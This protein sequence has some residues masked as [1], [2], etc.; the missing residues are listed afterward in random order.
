MI[1]QDALLYTEEAKTHWGSWKAQTSTYL[2]WTLDEL[3]ISSSHKPHVW[4]YC[5]N[6]P[7]TLAFRSHNY[8]PG[9]PAPVLSSPPEKDLFLMSNLSLPWCNSTLFLQD[10]SLLP[11][12]KAC[13]RAPLFPSRGSC[14]LS[15]CFLSVS[16]SLGWANQ[17]TS[18][19]ILPSRPLLFFTDSS[20]QSLIV[21]CPSQ[22]QCLRQ[23]C[24]S[25][26][27]SRTIP[28]L[29]QLCLIHSRA[30]LAFLVPR[31]HRWLRFNL[32]STRITRSHSI[33]LLSR[34]TPQLVFS[35]MQAFMLKMDQECDPL[36]HILGFILCSWS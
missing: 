14:R 4:E 28:S 35:F 23:S 22:A 12:K 24:I 5:P 13:L 9:E 34:L 10:L 29:D 2:L 3:I 20:G 8:C 36:N 33:R 19:Y 7:W 25:T 16:S 21:L 30:E 18:S 17:V 15:W 26:E 6:S 32:L 27:Q 11:E 1:L 31:A